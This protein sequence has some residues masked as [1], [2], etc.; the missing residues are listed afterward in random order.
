MSEEI[1]TLC[2]LGESPLVEEYAALCLS[3]G[4]AVQVRLNKATGTNR[5]PEGVTKVRKATRT[6]DLA[7]ELTNID[8]STKKR[9]LIELDSII[10]PQAPILSSSVTV[11]SAQQSRWVSKPG[12]LL[13]IGAFPSL[14]S[15]SLLELA[16][17][18]LTTKATISAARQ[19]AHMLEKETALIKDAVGMVMPRILS[20]V[21]NEACFALDD[22]VAP[23]SDI[24]SA[25]KLGADYPYGPLEWAERIG[26]RQLRA[27]IEALGR[28]IDKKRYTL[29]PLL[30]Q[31][32]VR[33][34]F[35][36]V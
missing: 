30:R 16:P 17:S 29:A 24:D 11:T 10:G 28:Q 19:F 12:R 34:A 22:K 8:T 2:L 4:F 1:R 13:G 15:C 32:A 23:R 3:K 27:V 5:L 26:P 31:A 6:V 20:M 21:V 14:L 35:P 9:N 7:L 25:M 36:A 33:N 18:P